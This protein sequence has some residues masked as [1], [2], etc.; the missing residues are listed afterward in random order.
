[1]IKRQII[2]TYILHR[3]QQLQGK[4]GIVPERQTTNVLFQRAFAGWYGGIFYYY[5]GYLY[6]FNNIVLQGIKHGD[7]VYPASKDMSF[8][9]SCK[10]QRLWAG[11]ENGAVPEAQPVTVW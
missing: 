6:L 1:M 7:F 3:H 2:P 5:N 11:K 10:G 9:S 8:C 4:D